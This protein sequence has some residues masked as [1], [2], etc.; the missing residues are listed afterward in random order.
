MIMIHEC[1]FSG[2]I[3]AKVIFGP[4][5]WFGICSRMV[6]VGWLAKG[7]TITIMNKHRALK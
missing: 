6:W 3:V 7:V 5:P 2:A 4:R 1:P